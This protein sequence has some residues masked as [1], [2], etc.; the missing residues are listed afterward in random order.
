MSFALSLA[1]AAS[2][3]ATIA[4]DWG[5]RRKAFYLFKPLTTLLIIALAVTLLP[6]GEQRTLLLAALGFCLVGDIVLMRHGTAAFAAGLSAFLVGHL[7]FI[8]AFWQQ[9][10]SAGWWLLAVPALAY[11]A[12]LQPRTGKL[13]PAVALYLAAIL[14]MALAAAGNGAPL[15]IVG[16]LLFMASDS[17]LAWR[18]FVKPFALGQAATLATYYGGLWCMVVGSAP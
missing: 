6:V 1:I 5:T 17:V 12:Y 18:R 7:L 4:S 14:G 13:W 2:A 8:V 3:V 11:F 10:P 16:A 9:A 15:L